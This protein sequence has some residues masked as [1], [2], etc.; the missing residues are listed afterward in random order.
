M[1]DGA[2]PRRLAIDVPLLV[3]SAPFPSAARVGAPAT[4]GCA[5]CGSTTRTARRSDT[6][7]SAIRRSSRSTS[8]PPS[9]RSRRSTRR[10]ERT[11]GFEA[12]LG[13]LLTVDRFRIDGIEPPFLKR[14]KLEGSGDREHWTLL[15]AEGTLFNLPDEKLLQTELRF[16]RRIVPLP[17]RHLGR[18]A[19]RAHLRAVPRGAAG[20]VP[21]ARD[22]RRR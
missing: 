19:Q 20:Q 5:I 9:C 6:C 7:W 1:T 8:R 21:A 18:H 17:P 16:R 12:D 15:V 13:E 11:S 4:D 14:L 10:T 2:G 22:D 3:G